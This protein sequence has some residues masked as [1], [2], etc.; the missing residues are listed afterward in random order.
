MKQS[1]FKIKIKE[2]AGFIIASINKTH[3]SMFTISLYISLNWTQAFYIKLNSVRKEI[4][5]SRNMYKGE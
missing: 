5:S 4:K 2:S 1:R 3:D